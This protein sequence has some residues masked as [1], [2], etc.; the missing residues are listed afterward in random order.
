MCL[1]VA[2][3]FVV[4]AFGDGYGDGAKVSDATTFDGQP[5]SYYLDRANHTGSTVSNIPFASVTGV[6]YNLSFSVPD[7]TNNYIFIQGHPF[8]GGGD[9]TIERIRTRTVRGD[10][11]GVVN[12]VVD[13]LSD[14]SESSPSVDSVIFYGTETEDTSIAGETSISNNQAIGIYYTLIDTFAVSNQVYTDIRIRN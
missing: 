5:A 14:I 13:D 12:V 8:D 7:P 3:L 6:V 4:T 11:T 2:V 10:V 9:F 1:S